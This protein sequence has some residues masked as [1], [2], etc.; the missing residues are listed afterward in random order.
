LE[1]VCLGFIDKIGGLVFGVLKGLLLVSIVVMIMN[2]FGATNLINEEIRASSRLFTFT[3]SIADVL[4][5][6]HEDFED[7]IEDVFEKS[8]DKMED[9]MEAIEDIVEA[10]L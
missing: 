1:A 4:Y 6:N 8:M 2:V 7:T 5:E 10:N 3:E 9:K